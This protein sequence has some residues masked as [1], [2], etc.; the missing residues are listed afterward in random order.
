MAAIN[1][2]VDIAVFLLER[3]GRI[4][5]NNL[6]KWAAIKAL[7]WFSTVYTGKIVNDCADNVCA[8]G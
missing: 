6:V 4:N 5:I 8:T 7:S 3:G 2:D 1:N